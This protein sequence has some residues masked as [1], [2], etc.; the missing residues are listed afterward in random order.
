MLADEPPA[1][2]RCG[3]TERARMQGAC[4]DHF[5]CVAGGST[6]IAECLPRRLGDY[7]FGFAAFG[8]GNPRSRS[9]AATS[10]SRPRKAR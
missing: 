2:L 8:A 9:S 7:F 4:D 5:E 3:E 1:P 10:G 6:T